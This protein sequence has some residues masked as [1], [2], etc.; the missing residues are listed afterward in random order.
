[1]LPLTHLWKMFFSKSN[2]ADYSR[3]NLGFVF[4]N[5]PSSVPPTRP[6]VKKWW[7]YTSFPHISYVDIKRKFIPNFFLPGQ[8]TSVYF[9]HQ[10]LFFDDIKENEKSR[11]HSTSSV[12]RTS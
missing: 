3:F 12:E 6:T 9:T 10:K 7:S 11:H 5:N 1:M 4:K 2:D 8:V